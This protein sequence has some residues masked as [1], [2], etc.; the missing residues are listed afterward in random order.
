MSDLNAGRYD[1]LHGDEHLPP[2]MTEEEEKELEDA[3]EWLTRAIVRDCMTGVYGFDWL[4]ANE[5]Y[6]DLARDV[7]GACAECYDGHVMDSAHFG[8]QCEEAI[9][10]QAA[11][12]AHDYIEKGDSY[13]GTTAETSRLEWL[14]THDDERRKEIKEWL[15]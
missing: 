9:R 11:I 8:F 7:Q 6:E 10:K 5:Q 4:R 13:T 3:K 15:K 1:K 14:A 12:F 2:D